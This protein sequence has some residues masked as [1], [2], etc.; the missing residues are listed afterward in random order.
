MKKIISM[1]LC[2]VILTLSLASCGNDTVVMPEADRPNVTLRMA[3]I[4]DD[5][6]TADGIAAME[7][8]F[9]L[10]SEVLL[11][12]HVE[13]ECIR[14][15][16]YR[17]KMDQIL[18]GVAEAGKQQSAAVEDAMANAGAGTEVDNAENKY[19]EAS[20]GQFDIILIKD[21]KMYNDYAT[22][23]WIKGLNSHL[24][25]NFKVLNTKMLPVVKEA[26]LL[27]GQCYGIPANKAYGE[28]T[29]VML[30]KQAIDAY[31][32]NTAEIKSLG[33]VKNLITA[34]ESSTSKGLDYWKNV[35]YKD[36]SFSVIRESDEKFVMPNLQY[37][38]QDFSSFSLIGTT[39]GIADTS[40]N[41]LKA[42]NL[43]REDTNY[44]NYLTVKYLANKGQ[45]Y[46]GD[47]AENFLI[48]L[49]KGDYA[50]RQTSG[51][52]EYIPLLYPILN[53]EDVFR[54]MLAVSSFTVDEKRSLEVIQELMTNATGADLLN[55]ALYGD[56]Q[57]NYT[58][59]T[60]D[61]TSCVDLR[62]YYNYAAHE[63]FLFGG[64]REWAYPCLDYGQTPA[65]YANAADH[66]K[67]LASRTPV[68]PAEFKTYFSGVDAEKWAKVDKFCQGFYEDLMKSE[69]VDAFYEKI[70]AFMEKL[71]EVEL[72]MKDENAEIDPSLENY[73]LFLELE[74]NGAGPDNRSSKTL[75]GSFY[76]YAM[77][78]K[79]LLSSVVEQ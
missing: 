53:T 1:L 7:A 54:G 30:N 29:Y 70:D 79:G 56:S 33:D 41:L 14:A 22:K 60:L 46:G 13:F 64:L 78:V 49:A 76:T 27:N 77:D 23:G 72:L 61:D 59:E 32:L 28:Y 57:S 37:L 20:Q 65:T 26:T 24:S 67:N 25:G 68:F 47:K 58:F 2:L 74:L 21:Q 18:S 44:Q 51:D 62:D 52:Y 39:Y 40:K 4:V 71:A 31:K 5:K 10:Q 12:T 43:L 66:I 6:T 45:Y 36:K 16:E 9:N 63:D 69:N 8:A 15:S 73:K 50:L 34:M 55:L 35:V 48:G 3:I 38:S 42:N 75:G 19:P 11:A 17:A